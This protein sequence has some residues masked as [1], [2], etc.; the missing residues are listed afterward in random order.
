MCDFK[1]Y[2][3]VLVAV[4]IHLWSIGTNYG[5]EIARTH[6]EASALADKVVEGDTQFA[7]PCGEVET[8]IET[9]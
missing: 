8:D 5:W 1:F 7:I 4:G 9:L 2:T 6:V 3:G